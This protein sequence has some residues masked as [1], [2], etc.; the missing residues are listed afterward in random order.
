ML[1][2]FIYN[3]KHIAS[4]AQVQYTVFGGILL[5]KCHKTQHY[6]PEPHITGNIMV[7]QS[8]GMEMMRNICTV[9]LLHGGSGQSRVI[10]GR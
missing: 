6:G 8:M 4:I 7:T 1:L 2:L 9:N 5:M 10:E 3:K